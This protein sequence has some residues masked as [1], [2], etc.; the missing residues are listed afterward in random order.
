MMPPFAYNTMSDGVNIKDN[1]ITIPTSENS[2]FPLPLE[3]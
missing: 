2:T 1:V 3:F